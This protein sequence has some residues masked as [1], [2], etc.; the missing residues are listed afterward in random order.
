[1]IMLSIRNIPRKYHIVEPNMSINI[2]PIEN[3]RIA[4]ISEPI[5]EPIQTESQTLCF[6]RPVSMPIIVETIPPEPWNGS[7]T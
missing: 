7:A 6:F 1:M 4:M 2:S 5:K 3:D